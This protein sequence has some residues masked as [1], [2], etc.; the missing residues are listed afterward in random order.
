[1]D[2]LLWV[3]CSGRLCFSSCW[4]LRVK[5]V[6]DYSQNSF[7]RCLH[8]RRHPP[9]PVRNLPHR[10]LKSTL[11]LS[12]QCTFCSYCRRRSVGVMTY[13]LQSRV[14]DLFL[15]LPRC[16]GA[17]AQCFD[18]KNA[19]L[20]VFTLDT[21]AGSRWLLYNWIVTLCSLSRCVCMFVSYTRV[22]SALTLY[23]GH[24]CEGLLK[25]VC[26]MVLFSYKCFPQKI[27]KGHGVSGWKHFSL[28]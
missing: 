11:R 6:H 28:V 24:K 19:W 10:L 15:P 5:L 25:H 20:Q 22:K 16:A 2:S 13:A 23:E 27:C 17:G 21:G 1:M 18:V 4:M 9:L 12:E 26:W 14:I 7:P 8:V 3:S